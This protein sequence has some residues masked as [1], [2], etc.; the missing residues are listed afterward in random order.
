MVNTDSQQLTENIKFQHH[1]VNTPKSAQVDWIL[2]KKREL[3]SAITNQ[4]TQ[5]PIDYI[6]SV[7]NL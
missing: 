1:T 6:Y 7:Q 3:K 4:R 5:S 2:W